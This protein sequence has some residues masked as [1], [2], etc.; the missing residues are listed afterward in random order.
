MDPKLMTELIAKLQ[1]GQSAL[2][3]ALMGLLIDKGVLTRED[4]IA[5]LERVSAE[6]SRSEGGLATASV[7][8]NVL[9]WLRS[10]GPQEPP[11]SSGRSH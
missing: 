6:A 10:T 4:L 11:E 2:V 7:V 5:E 3:M 1:A 9:N 8:D